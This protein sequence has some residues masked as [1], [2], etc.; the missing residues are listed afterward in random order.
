MKAIIQ[1]QKEG[2]YYIATDIITNVADQ[3]LTRDEAI[4]NLKEGLE[5][6]YEGIIEHIPKKNEIS[7]L[8]INVESYVKATDPIC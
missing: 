6:Y 7:F 8:N 1:I 2:K 3:G 5:L 4:S